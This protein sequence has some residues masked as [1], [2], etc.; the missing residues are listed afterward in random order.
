MKVYAFKHENDQ[1][2]YALGVDK[3]AAKVPSGP[4]KYWKDVTIR[5]KGVIGYDP[6]KAAKDIEAQGWHLHRW[7]A[8]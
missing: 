6:V 5:P 3:S 7:P 8:A 4:W 1:T 2:L